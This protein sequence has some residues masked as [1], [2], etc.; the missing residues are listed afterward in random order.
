MNVGFTFNV[1][2]IN[3]SIVIASSLVFL[4]TSLMIP[5]STFNVQAQENYVFVQEFAPNQQFGNPDIT[6]DQ[7]HNDVV[8]VA[9][10]FNNRIVKFYS[11]G[12][13][14]TQWGSQGSSDGQFINPQDV[15]IDS[16]GF[17]YVVDT[18]NHRI[19]KFTDSGQFVTQWG[20]QGSSD[21]QF[22]FPDR[23]AIDTS[24]FIYVTDDGNGRVQ[25]FTTTGM[26]VSK[27]GENHLNVPVGIGT[28]SNN[29]VYVAES[30][31]NRVSKF[32][33][34]GQLITTWGSS[35][36]G[37]GQFN[38]PKGLTL[39]QNNNV[40]VADEFNNRIQK[41]DSNGNFITEFGQD[42]LGHPMCAID[43]QAR[44]Y[45]SDENNDQILIYA[46][47]NQIPN[48]HQILIEHLK[49][50]Y[51]ITGTNGPDTLM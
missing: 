31:G 13:V 9:D 26:F 12:N 43:S 48:H 7:F 17:I 38:Q 36:A 23:I 27:F 21:G 33:S 34:T 40:F 2:G 10:Y 39:D 37:P 3:Q 41:F 46:L 35:G 49:F 51:I 47:A 18:R 22:N 11:S 6:I 32:T 14:I 29:N 19:Q 50:E 25:K 8:Y 20:S 4:V 5:S 45:A 1:R 16:A 24:D 28:D 44:V 15:G 30:G 42:R